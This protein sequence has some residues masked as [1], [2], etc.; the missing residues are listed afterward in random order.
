V[1][2]TPLVPDTGDTNYGI[3]RRKPSKPVN[4]AK[5]NLPDNQITAIWFG[6]LPNFKKPGAVIAYNARIPTIKAN[7]EKLLLPKACGGTGG[8]PT[9]K[10]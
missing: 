6:R 5:P 3:C 8:I 4:P 9:D 7:I 1:V 10:Q 2:H